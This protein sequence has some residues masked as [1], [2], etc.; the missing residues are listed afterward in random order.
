ML[1]HL[2]LSG[3]SGDPDL[4]FEIPFYRDPGGQV[5]DDLQ[6]LVHRGVQV[7]ILRFFGVGPAVAAQGG[8]DSLGT[9]GTAPNHFED[10]P[11]IVTTW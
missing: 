11:D 7:G 9:L 6:G 2:Q 8:D 4:G 3:T 10:L 1:P 5:G